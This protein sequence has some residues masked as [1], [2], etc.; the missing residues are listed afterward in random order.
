MGRSEGRA[1]EG[2]RR[3]EDHQGAGHA[4]RRRV[5]L[6]P[7]TPFKDHDKTLMIGNSDGAGDAGRLKVT[8]HHNLFVGVERAPR[9]PRA[10]PGLVGKRAGAGGA[11]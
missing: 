5:R 8:L 3:P 6:S 11:G 7:G 4:R 9:A 10:L 1:P 2:R